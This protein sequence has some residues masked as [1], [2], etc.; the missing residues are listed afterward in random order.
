MVSMKDTFDRLFRES[1]EK[2]A[3]IKSQNEQ[4]VGLKKQLEKKLSEASNKGS[5]EEDFDIESNHDEESNDER[6]ARK[7]CCLGSISVK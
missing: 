5:D 3:Q 7:D 6:K 4:I 1:A 2:D